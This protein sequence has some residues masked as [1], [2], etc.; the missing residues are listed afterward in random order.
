[1][2]LKL[3][4]T[5]DFSTF[6]KGDNLWLPFGFLHTSHLLEKGS[7]LKAKNLLPRG[8]IFP[9]RG[10][11]LKGKNLLLREANHFLLK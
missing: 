3:L 9:V 1:M 5:L 2:C 6:Y 10:S 7:T 11:T 4:D 8:A